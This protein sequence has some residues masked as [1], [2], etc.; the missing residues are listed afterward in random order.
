MSDAPTVGPARPG[1]GAP[2]DAADGL[3]PFVPGRLDAAALAEA[4][5][6]LALVHALLDELGPGLAEACGNVAVDLKAD[7]TPVTAIDRETDERVAD[8]L[9]ARFPGHTVLSEERTTTATGTSWAWVV[10]PIDGT[11]NFITGLPHWC[12]SIALCL[13]GAPVLGVVD[14]PALR[15]RWVAV[16]GQGT[17]RD[18]R[19]VR[20]RRHVD[21]TAAAHAHVPVML[22]S[23]AARHLAGAGLRMNPRLA[24]AV[25]LDLALV[26]DGSAAASVAWVPHVWDVAA[27]LVLVAEAGG[28]AVQRAA[29]ALLP[30]EPGVAYAARTA[31][32][33]TAPDATALDGLL[34][35]LPPH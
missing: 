15:R 14:A 1:P 34:A 11:S 7:G 8:A 3:V 31:L 5:R 19:P 18:G 20:V 9:T 35:A 24:G 4:E 27:G 32:T 30:L 22:T 6:G 21:W 28:V 12:V 10:D 13:E 23:T 16:A 25:A 17:R 33:A 26:A 2:G 29:T